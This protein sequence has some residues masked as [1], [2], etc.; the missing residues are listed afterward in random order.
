[1][2]TEHHMELLR[3]LFVLSAA[4]AAAIGDIVYYFTAE[5][6]YGRSTFRNRV[7]I[8][9]LLFATFLYSIFVRFVLFACSLFKVNARNE[10]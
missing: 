10:I 4:A 1:M 9:F 3:L 6:V 8:E 2:N 5:V 7:G